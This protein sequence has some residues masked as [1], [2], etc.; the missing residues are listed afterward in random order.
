M[1]PVLKTINNSHVTLETLK[2]FNEYIDS[3]YKCRIGYIDKIVCHKQYAA[4]A[5]WQ[6]ATMSMSAV[7]NNIPVGYHRILVQYL[8]NN[9]QREMSI[10]DG[11]NLVGNVPISHNGTYI[12]NLET[13]AT[14]G[15]EEAFGTTI[16]IEIRSSHGEIRIPIPEGYDGNMAFV[17]LTVPYRV[18]RQLLFKEIDAANWNSNAL[19]T[20]PLAVATASYPHAKEGYYRPH[21]L[22]FYQRYCKKAASGRKTL[23]LDVAKSKNW[24]SIMTHADSF[25]GPFKKGAGLDIAPWVEVSITCYKYGVR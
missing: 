1:T 22:L 24:I 4:E 10:G 17:E 15:I 19:L 18:I 8:R 9:Y 2:A 12:I 25:N 20:H 13:G 3:V 11:T 21:A 23:K 7:L 5:G 6:D 16:P 14:I